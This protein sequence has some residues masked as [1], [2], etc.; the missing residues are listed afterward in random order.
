MDWIVSFRRLRRKPLYTLTIALALGIGVGAVTIV[1]SWF[2]GLF[3]RPLPAVRDSRSLQ[4]LELRRVDY[5]TTAFSY[6]DYRD[7]A[8][9]LAPS[10]D[11][12]SYSMTRVTLSGAGKPEQHWALFVSGNFFSTLEL[13]AAPDD[14]SI[15]RT[16]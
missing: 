10:M 11:L 4:V 1:F 16:P 9:A 5:S 7:M 3:L 2:E 12:L 6:P 13:E 8:E 14:C 15:R